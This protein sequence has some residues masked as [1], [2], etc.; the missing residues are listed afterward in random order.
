MFDYE[1]AADGTVAVRARVTAPLMGE[2]VV[3]WP[4]LYLVAPTGAVTNVAVG[5]MEIQ[6]VGRPAFGPAGRLYFLARNPAWRSFDRNGRIPAGLFRYRP[7]ETDPVAVAVP[8]QDV[9]GKPEQ[10]L[11]GVPQRPVVSPKAVAFAA[12]FGGREPFPVSTAGLFTVPLDGTLANGTLVAAEG[13]GLPLTALVVGFHDFYYT[14][15]ET[16]LFDTFVRQG[17]VVGQLIAT[18]P[19]RATAAAV[20]RSQA[21][22]PAQLLVNR[23]VKGDDLGEGR[24]LSRVLG[25]VLTL[26]SVRLL[27]AAQFSQPTGAGEGL[28]SIDRGNNIQK[29]AV[30]GDP[31]T[32]SGLTGA[33]F[34]GFGEAPRDQAA[35]SEEAARYAAYP[36]S[37]SADESVV[38]KARLQRGGGTISGLFRWARGAAPAPVAVSDVPLML[39]DSPPYEFKNWAAGA[40]GRTYFL[41]QPQT[42][43]RASMARLFEHSAAGLRP[44]VIPGQTRVASGNLSILTG[45][46]DFV[47]SGFGELFVQGASAN[48]AAVLRVDPTGL[49]PVAVQGQPVPPSRGGRPCSN[50]TG[51]AFDG[52]FDLRRDSACSDLLF[53]AEVQSMAQPPSVT[54][55]LFRRQSP[56]GLET[57]LVQSIT[58]AGARDPTVCVIPPDQPCGRSFGTLSTSQQKP[59]EFLAFAARESSGRW[60]IYRV[61]TVQDPTTGKPSDSTVV[62]AREGQQLPDG[63]RFISLDPSILLGRPTDSGPVFTLSPAGDVAFLAS[64]GQRWAIYRFSDRS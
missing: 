58:V 6:P 45:L 62:I 32:G 23:L 49:T 57:L 19:P 26:S 59:T 16:L 29:V 39:G 5:R 31:A 47:L 30:T 18:L 53:A 44:L 54:R 13:A 37:I 15:D 28:F 9:P 11:L 40:S 61:Q 55:G 14:A 22:T 17:L 4:G 48:G 42:Q 2:P 24:K 63:T 1:I 38:F 50:S 43:P 51:L 8:G 7:G 10:Q 35:D 21:A 33:R 34:I 60:A 36:P 41:E 46:S 56:G 25:Q 3:A 52:T 20:S 12:L 64:D 27:F